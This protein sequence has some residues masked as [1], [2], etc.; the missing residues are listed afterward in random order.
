MIWI[1]RAVLIMAIAGGIG[2][3]AGPSC[4]PPDPE[5]TGLALVL[6]C[7]A[8]AGAFWRR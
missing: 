7:A 1:T 2:S 6:C 4:L 8:L 5:V 3:L